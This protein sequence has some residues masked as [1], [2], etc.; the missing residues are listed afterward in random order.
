MNRL[1]VECSLE[2]AMKKFIV[3]LSV[4]A[5]AALFAADGATAA[6]Y[7]SYLARHPGVSAKAALRNSPH[8]RRLLREQQ[9]VATH[10]T[11][12]PVNGIIEYGSAFVAPDS[13]STTA[14]SVTVCRPARTTR[15]GAVIKPGNR[16]HWLR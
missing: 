7:H 2:T 1:G 4:A 5:V 15:C 13:A 6:S 14:T 10:N 3:T 12:A 11:A 16:R 9:P 8:V